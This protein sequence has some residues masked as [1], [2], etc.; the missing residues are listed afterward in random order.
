VQWSAAMKETV[1]IM[2]GRL[3]QL[4]QRTDE[5]HEKDCAEMARCV[6]VCVCVCALL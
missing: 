4:K 6:C 5:Q 2:E 1:A 3:A